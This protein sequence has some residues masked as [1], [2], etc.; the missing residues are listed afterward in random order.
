MQALSPPAVGRPLLSASCHHGRGTK[1]PLAEPKFL[2]GWQQQPQQLHG[3]SGARGRRA[4]LAQFVVGTWAWRIPASP[5][6][7]GTLRE[8]ERWD[9]RAR[10]MPALLLLLLPA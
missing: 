4:A 6:P 2:W 7:H 8:R 3:L 9:E 5:A 10:T 1:S